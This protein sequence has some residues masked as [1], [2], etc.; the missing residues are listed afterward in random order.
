MKITKKL[1]LDAFKNDKETHITL[2][3]KSVT[4]LKNDSALMPARQTFTPSPK[5]KR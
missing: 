1:S 2:D 5:R 4:R 3:Q